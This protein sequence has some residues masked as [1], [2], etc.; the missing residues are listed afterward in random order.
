VI[1]SSTAFQAVRFWWLW[2]S[3]EAAHSLKG[4]ATGLNPYPG[5]RAGRQTLPFPTV[6]GKRISWCYTP[7]VTLGTGYRG[8]GTVDS[9]EWIVAS[10]R[11]LTD[12]MNRTAKRATPKTSAPSQGLRHPPVSGFERCAPLVES[13]HVIRSR[14]EGF[15]IVSR[16]RRRQGARPIGLEGRRASGIYSRTDITYGNYLSGRR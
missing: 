15:P 2:Q 1:L 4:C 7:I 10:I 9:G 14:P 12:F 3:R 16:E 13:P 11:R 8:Q 5:T 6:S